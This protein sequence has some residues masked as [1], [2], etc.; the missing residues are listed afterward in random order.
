MVTGAFLTSEQMQT[1]ATHSHK[2]A[3]LIVPLGLFDVE[4]PVVVQ[5][6]DEQLLVDPDG[7]VMDSEALPS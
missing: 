6:P 2:G 4:G 5:Y 7:R 3:A 1:L